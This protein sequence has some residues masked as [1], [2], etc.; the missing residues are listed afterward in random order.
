MRSGRRCLLLLHLVTACAVFAGVTACDLGEFA[1]DRVIVTQ[2]EPQSV[3][4]SGEGGDPLVIY[5]VVTW[6]KEGWCS[7]QFTVQA[8]ESLTEVRVGKVTSRE[9]PGGSCAGV[10][11]VDNMAGA[12]L[13]LASP[14]GDRVVVRDSDGARLPIH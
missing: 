3:G 14:L 11:T 2:L 6:T 9:Y 7:G 12:S 5:I 10:G 13:R 8:T 4:L 1:P